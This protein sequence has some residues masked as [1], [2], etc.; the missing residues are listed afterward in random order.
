M[1]GARWIPRHFVPPHPF[2]AH[3]VRPKLSPRLRA[4][5]DNFVEL[6]RSNLSGLEA[7]GAQVISVPLSGFGDF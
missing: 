6:F 4:L 3:S 1:P 2:G 7:C 5:R